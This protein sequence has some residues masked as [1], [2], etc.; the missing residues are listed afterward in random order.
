MNRNDE[1]KQV[2]E[3]LERLG[4]QA[5]LDASGNILLTLES[6]ET[7]KRI[8]LPPEEMGKLLDKACEVG[9][10]NLADGIFEGILIALF[11]REY[12]YCK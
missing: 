3:K 12:V 7:K 9:V 10:R 4:I 2:I 5:A 1:R 8:C 6:R 11:N